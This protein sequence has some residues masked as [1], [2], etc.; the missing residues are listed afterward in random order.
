MTNEPLD[1]RPVF[2]PFRV[3]VRGGRLT[4]FK[5]QV[6]SLAP[7][8]LVAATAAVLF[9]GGAAHADNECG[10]DGAGQD[11]VTCGASD[12][13]YPNYTDGI[14]YAFS[15]GLTLILPVPP[16]DGPR[17]EV[18][19]KGVSVSGSGTGEGDIS[20]QMDGGLVT[21]TDVGR[22]GVVSLFTNGSG[23]AA[24]TVRMTDGAVETTGDISHGLVVGNSGAG[25][26]RVQMDG[27]T[28]TTTGED[29][30]GISAISFGG[31]AVVDLGVSATVTASGAGAHGIHV[32]GASGFDIDVAGVV[33]GG[34]F[35]EA[36]PTKEAIDGAA[37]RTTSSPG[38]TIDIASGAEVNAGTSGLAIQDG[39][40]DAVVTSAGKLTGDVRL[41]AG[42]DSLTISSTATYDFSYTLDG[43]EGGDDHLTLH[44]QTMTSMENVI[45]WE[46][47]TMIGGSVTTQ[48]AEVHGLNAVSEGGPAVV[49]LGENAVVRASGM[50][51]DG[52]RAEGA[53]GFDVGVAGRV[54]GGAHNGAA[55]RTISSA[56]G[57][58]DIASGAEVNAGTSGLAIQDGNGDAAVILEGTVNGDI[59]LGSGDDSLTIGATANYDFSHILD[60]G[61]GDYDH[62]ILSGRTMTSMENVIDWEHLTLKDETKLSLDKGAT[63]DMD[64]SIEAGSVFSVSGGGR[65]TGATIAGN[66]ANASGGGLTIVG[67]VTNSGTLSVQDGAAGDVIRIEGNYTGSGSSVFALDADGSN[68]DRLVITGNASGETMLS[69]AGLDS[70]VPTGAPLELNLVTVGG[71][72]DDATF[73]LMGNYVT[74]DEERTVVSGA[75]LYRLAA[76]EDGR[77]WMLSAR[78]ESGE[79]SWGPSAPIYDS[80][81]ASLLA[82]N[83]PSG[84][85]ARG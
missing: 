9:T 7:G 80:Y 56:G 17:I 70:V 42:D 4:K 73:T 59:R 5:G 85:H 48:G 34:A 16:A 44:G 24:A 39:D 69:V 61:L 40:G 22:F 66:V 54:T 62:L 74:A 64:L 68:N 53:T 43:G 36:T 50:N 15:D 84:L 57:T 72:S 46:R 76:A 82:F 29:A 27:G 26:A 63:L 52:I 65:G 12:P 6:A 32:L 77:S 55:I 75:Y 31:R 20:V 37:I 18:S 38:G 71:A 28:V 1:T 21:T 3:L 30:V 19:G 51:A 14:N 23:T 33:S 47:L 11:T 8:C 58:I 78:L 81:G 83:A 79:I 67:D 25:E 13:S 35:R 49:D 10:T 41:G 45:N 2:D 60:G